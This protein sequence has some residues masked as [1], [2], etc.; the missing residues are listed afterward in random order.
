[1]NMASL[2]FTPLKIRE[3]ILKNRIIVSPMCQYSAI[4]GVPNEWHMVHLGSRAVGGAAVVIVEATAVE[5]IGRISDH[6]LALYN[7]DQLSAFKPITQFIKSQ[8]SIP[9]IQLAHAGRKASRGDSLKKEH[10]LSAEE[11]G[12]EVI[13]PSAIAFNERYGFP[14]EISHLE[15]KE[16]VETFKHSAKLALDAGFQI[17]EIHSAHGYLLHEFLSPLSNNRTDE[18]G[19]SLKNR[20][21]FPLMI[22]QALRDLWPQHLPV[23]VRVSATDWTEGGWTIEDSVIYSKELKKIGIDLIDA[24]TGGVIGTAKIP[25]SPGYQVTFAAQIKKESGIL[26]GAVGLI[27]DPKQAEKILI[28]NKADVIIMARELLREP[29]WPIKAAQVLG[30]KI[31]VPAQYER[32][33]K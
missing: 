7:Q 14:R 5:S 19:G 29:Y 28:E 26:T 13:A 23:F 2:L 21:R 22:A 8:G 9:A 27:T 25:L 11:G 31:E 20:M 18:Y 16:L 17:I 24:S 10:L 12:W 33:Y 30:D 32:A 1:M 15:I 4:D 6:D 3:L